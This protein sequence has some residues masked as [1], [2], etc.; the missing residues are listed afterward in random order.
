M[1]STLS[2]PLGVRIPHAALAQLEALAQER[3]QSRGALAT[4]ALLRGLEL[5]ASEHD[6]RRSG[7][8]DSKPETASAGLAAFAEAALDSARKSRG[9]H[10]GEDRVFINHVWKRFRRVHP[11]SGL[12]LESFK[13][14]LLEANRARLLSLA[15]ADMSPMLERKDVEASEIHY[16][17]ATF[18]FLCI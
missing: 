12:D 11:A 1:P 2:K 16:L 7:S 18:H 15:R 13:E 6:G 17:T 3:G 4:E 5:L 8:G 9:G 10:F 14:R